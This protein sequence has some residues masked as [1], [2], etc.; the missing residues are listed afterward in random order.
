MRGSESSANG[1]GETGESLGH[2]AER[3]NCPPVG[4]E[5]EDVANDVPRMQFAFIPHQPSG[6]HSTLGVHE[7]GRLTIRVH[8][9]VEH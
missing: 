3:K 9:M 5:A 2:V 4:L 7:A 6:L 8:G 1:S